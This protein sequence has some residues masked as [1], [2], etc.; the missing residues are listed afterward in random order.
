MIQHGTVAMIELKQDGNLQGGIR[1]CIIVSN[2]K[3]CEVSPVLTVVPL[4]SKTKRPLP[5]HVELYPSIESG[6][7]MTST[8]LAEQI[9]TI[10]RTSIKRVMGVL[11]SIEIKLIKKAIQ[12]SLAL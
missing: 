10:N 1:P 5:T 9:T 6:I 4:T 11:T 12:K 3:A 8:F 7:S 2:N